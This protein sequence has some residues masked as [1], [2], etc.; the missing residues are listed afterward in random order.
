M[1]APPNGRWTLELEHVLVNGAATWNG[2]V[3]GVAIVSGEGKTLLLRRKWIR[4]KQ[5]NWEALGED[6]GFGFHRLGEFRQELK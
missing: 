1:R 6:E 2:F 5:R 3:E 4:K